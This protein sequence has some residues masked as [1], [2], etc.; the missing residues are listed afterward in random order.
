[1]VPVPHGH[2]RA[3]ASPHGRGLDDAFE[4]LFVRDE[5]VVA[6]EALYAKFRTNTLPPPRLTP[7][8]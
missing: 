3:A 6:A 1:V 4:H 5:Q 8:C 7:T 2:Q